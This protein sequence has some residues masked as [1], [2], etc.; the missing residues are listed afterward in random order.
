MRLFIALRL[1][2]EIISSLKNAIDQLKKQSI[3]ARPVRLE[4]LHLTLAFIGETDR[5]EDIIRIINQLDIH[6]FDIRIGTHG[7]FDRLYW[8]GL[9]QNPI[10]SKLAQDIRD[11]L[12]RDGF[13]I[14]KR[15]FIPH[16]TIARNVRPYDKIDI[17]VKPAQMTV[18]RISLMKSEQSDGRVI[19]TEVY[20]RD[21]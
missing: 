12:I 5:T 18:R 10:L 14:E 6:S 17:D 3:S 11:G 13:N 7:N 2:N 9:Q 19:Y 1:S 8:V 4:N 21:I 15:P 16:I 20:G